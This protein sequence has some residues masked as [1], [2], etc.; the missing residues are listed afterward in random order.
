MISRPARAAEHPLNHAVYALFPM[1][2]AAG[3]CL[4]AY[5]VLSPQEAMR[6]ILEW[7]ERYQG[8]VRAR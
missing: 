3:T 8:P 2:I 4:G 1:S 7:L 5:E 6:E